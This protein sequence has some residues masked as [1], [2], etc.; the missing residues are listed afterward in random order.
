GLTE[1]Q[2]CA[3]KAN[4]LS[5]KFSLCLSKADANVSKGRV[6]DTVAADAKCETKFRDGWGKTR[7]KAQDK[8]A[9][10]GA[11]CDGAMSDAVRDSVEASALITAGRHDMTAFAVSEAD[12]AD[13][14]GVQ[15]LID[16]AV[17]AVDITSDNASLCTD[18]G[19]TYDAGTDTCSVDITSDN[20]T[21]CEA[22]NGTWESG[23]CTA[24]ETAYDC[25]R[26]G[27]CG[28]SG[29]NTGVYA[30]DV[31]DTNC[32]YENNRFGYNL[33]S[34]AENLR[35]WYWPQDTIASISQL[36]CEVDRC[37]DGVVDNWQGETCDGENLGGETCPEATCTSQCVL[38]LP[39]SCPPPF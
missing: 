14:S 38:D 28:S 22:A 31:R 35:A 25:F 15:E 5:G 29:A 7:E 33:W 12:L 36:V 34:L 21:V 10:L 23:T 37:G 13:D 1:G 9:S 26:G 16:E 24:A 2:K 19:G 3:M 32:S 17:A 18:A 6:L 20:Q 11:D 27:L 39:P 30:S 4:L 8:D